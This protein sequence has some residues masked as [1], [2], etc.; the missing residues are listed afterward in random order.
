MKFWAYFP[1]YFAIKLTV[2]MKCFEIWLRL[3]AQ[4][5]FYTLTVNMKCFEITEE[6]WVYAKIEKLTVNMKCF[7]IQL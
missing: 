5:K 7:E 6:F 4:G 1:L 2:N 3:S